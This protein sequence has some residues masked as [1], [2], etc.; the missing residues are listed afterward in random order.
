MAITYCFSSTFNDQF[1]KLKPDIKRATLDALRKFKENPAAKSLRFHRLSSVK[2]P[3]WKIDVFTDHSWQI[4]MRID[5]DRCTL[6]TIGT[7]KL[8]DR[9]Y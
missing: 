3:V 7:H 4:A 9:V 1:A 8:M 2:P 5:G 6:L